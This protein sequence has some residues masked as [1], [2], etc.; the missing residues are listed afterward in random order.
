MTEALG[1]EWLGLL[2]QMLPFIAEAMEDDDEG[3]EREVRKW[4]RIIEEILGESI[5]SMLQ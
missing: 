5:S 3:V 4:V 2:S 1:E